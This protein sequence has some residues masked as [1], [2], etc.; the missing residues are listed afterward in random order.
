M[1]LRDLGYNTVGVAICV[2]QVGLRRWLMNKDIDISTGMARLE[3]AISLSR[4]VQSHSWLKPV[5][6][7]EL[8]EFADVF[9]GEGR[10]RWIMRQLN[11]GCCRSAC[12][13]LGIRGGP[14]IAR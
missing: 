9:L 11:N 3:H 1:V 8:D 4:A 5:P 6:L 13:F 12:W 10:H 2:F 14:D 7:R